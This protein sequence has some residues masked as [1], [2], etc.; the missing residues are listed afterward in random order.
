[1]ELLKVRVHK[2]TTVLF[3]DDDTTTTVKHNGT[4][5]FD[6]A[7]AVV[8]GHFFKSMGVSKGT[9]K[10]WLSQFDGITVDA[11]YELEE[12]SNN[13]L[14]VKV[15]NKLIRKGNKIPKLAV[16]GISIQVKCEDSDLFKWHFTI[17]SYECLATVHKPSSIVFGLE[18][19][20]ALYGET[21]TGLLERM[22]KE[23]GHN[24]PSFEVLFKWL[25]GGIL[26]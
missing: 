18:A 14:E 19:H 13:P 4:G 15:K 26:E 6:T 12:R 25:A 11:I 16:G 9:A 2:G 8:W 20:S 5:E 24:R 17:N 22:T 7:T 23:I 10:E 21:K 1:M 3:W